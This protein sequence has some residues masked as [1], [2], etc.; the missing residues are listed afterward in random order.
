ME[1]NKSTSVLF[2]INRFS[3]VAMANSHMTHI[4][5]FFADTFFG[6]IGVTSLILARNSPTVI[7][8]GAFPTTTPIVKK[9]VEVVNRMYE[10]V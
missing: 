10:L 8:A 2:V 9:G 7:P 3:K 5:V 6:S 1:I 4:G